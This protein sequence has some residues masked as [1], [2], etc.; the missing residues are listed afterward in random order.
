[1]AKTKTWV[2]EKRLA[3]NSLKSMHLLLQFLIFN[4]KHFQLEKV[5]MVLAGWS[6]GTWIVEAEVGFL[7]CWSAGSGRG[8][9]LQKQERRG[10]GEGFASSRSD[11]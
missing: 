3:A 10:V 7:L 6:T 4:H 11:A 9:P 1:M 8:T 5:F 2:L